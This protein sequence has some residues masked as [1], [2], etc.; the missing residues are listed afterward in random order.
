MLQTSFKNY[1]EFKELFVRAKANGETTRRNGVLLAFLTSKQVWDYIKSNK[2]DMRR[3]YYSAPTRA[4]LNSMGALFA[5][6]KDLLAYAEWK[7]LNTTSDCLWEIN[8]IDR[9]YYSNV[10][11]SD[12][13]K[14]ICIDGDFSAYRYQNKERGGQVF[15]MK[16]GRMFRHIIDL[17]ELKDVLP[18]S[19]KLWVCEEITREWEAYAAASI[20][21][22]IE[23]HVDDDFRSIYDCGGDTRCY[24]SFGSCMQNA[25]DHWKFYR[26]AVKAKA[27]YLTQKI[28]DE[29]RII[30]RCI[31][32]TDV[33][34]ED[35][36]EVIRVAERQYSTDG[37]DLYQRIL[38]KKLKDGGYIDAYKKTG[39]GCG[40][41]RAFVDLAGN[42]MSDVHMHIDCDLDYGDYLSYQDSFKWYNECERIA[43]NYDSDYA[44]GQLD[45]TDLYY[46][47]D[48]DDEEDMEWDSWHE[49]DAE[50]V[51]TV[52][53]NG[54]E[55][56][57]DDDDMDDFT[58]VEYGNGRGE[59][60]HY[61]DVTYCCDVDG[62]V[63]N[64]DAYYSELLNEDYYDPDQMK[65]NEKQYK[66]DSGWAY[67]EWNDDYCE[68]EKDIESII[69]D[70]LADGSFERQTIFRQ[71][72][73]RL[74]ARGQAVMDEETGNVYM[75]DVLER[76]SA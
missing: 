13:K 21:D 71:S 6:V 54:R 47:G 20:P 28:D 24:G 62:Y 55:Y 58:Y 26:D 73:Y 66:K 12:G 2:D 60:H 63:L 51:T 50:S 32:F 41:A 8:I 10:Y 7:L 34:R 11:E 75:M 40:D 15:K 31:V 19:V 4:E 22:G 61:D 68:D 48:D 16:V 53:V 29:E 14:G 9:T 45:E 5:A 3:R 18:E 43:Y 56:T 42:S 72:I 76:L 64:D 27:A 35:T 1:D 52:Y 33:T 38:I 65:E 59:Y 74:V 49:R 69:T 70:V 57:C 37:N 44:D 46:G 36:G 23:L 25:G 39:A 17:T 67:A 30:A